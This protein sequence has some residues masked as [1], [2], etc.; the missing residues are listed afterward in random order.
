MALRCGSSERGTT[1][2][3]E[4]LKFGLLMVDMTLLV[5][6]IALELRKHKRGSE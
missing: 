1:M 2:K 4:V 6:N 3:L 5:M